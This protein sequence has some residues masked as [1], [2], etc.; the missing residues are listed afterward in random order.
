M[1]NII[2][3]VK[4]SNN[5]VILQWLAGIK[6]GT[7][8]R[9]KQ[10]KL[11]LEKDK[12]YYYKSNGP[13]KI[14]TI[15]VWNWTRQTNQTDGNIVFIQSQYTENVRP[16]EIIAIELQ[17]QSKSEVANYIRSN[18]I[19]AKENGLD[20]LICFPSSEKENLYDGVYCKNDEFE[21]I[22]SKLHL[23]D[24]IHK[25]PLF[26]I[27]SNEI[28]RTK[29]YDFYYRL[30]LGVANDFIE[31][32]E[33]KEILIDLLLEHSDW[34][35]MSAKGLSQKDYKI[36][37]KYL[38]DFLNKDF[39]EEFAERSGCTLT[40]AKAICRDFIKNSGTYLQEKSD[41][42]N[43]FIDDIFEHNRSLREKYEK[44]VDE[45]WN[46]KHASKI[47]AEQKEYDNLKQKIKNEQSGLQQLK[48]D[49]S[50][51]IK[52]L[53]QEKEKEA[54]ALEKW[55]EE[56]QQKKVNKEI[57]LNILKDQIDRKQKQIKELEQKV[58]KQ[59]EKAEKITNQADN[60]IVSQSK[61]INSI[62]SPQDVE[63]LFIEGKPLADNDIDECANWSDMCS[64]LKENFGIAGVDENENSILTGFVS[65]LYAAYLNEIPVLLA[66]PNAKNIAD[67]F[68]AAVYGKTADRFN[69]EGQYQITKLSNG[70]ESPFTVIDNVFHA[71]WLDHVDDI[72]S[73]FQYC[74][75][76][77]AFAE[78]LI[79][80]PR[81]LY[82][83]MIPV[84]TDL[85]VTVRPDTDPTYYGKQK[86]DFDIKGEDRK[87]RS[88]LKV[89]QG[90]GLGSL[91][92]RNIEMILKTLNGMPGYSDDWAYYFVL[93]P[94]AILTG[95]ER[96]LVETI[97]SSEKIS[98]DCRDIIMQYLGDNQ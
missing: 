26:Q 6:D 61:R 49:L 24:N 21:I 8:V 29:Q 38:N 41:G 94:Y 10:D 83:Y 44:R 46:E 13:E 20:V 57:E 86:Q 95:N 82:N 14:G 9:L 88:C 3:E 7:I 52:V 96:F 5:G 66:G 15:G 50:S 31:L 75:F 89:L 45:K 17:V 67:A 55:K 77:N 79:I 81:G 22:D 28:V 40:D 78:N 93:L 11:R 60:Q 18:A 54:H 25:F 85:F 74:W 16:I 30:E 68:S 32:K 39:Y 91:Y 63:K 4:P 59:R 36:V 70:N 92:R 43:Q 53:K 76:T 1:S 19:K 48:N 23:K 65:Y 64:I 35:S 72:T 87:I 27:D 69:C 90:F 51:E 42:E 2:C 73:E 34:A 62:E 80:E 98:N 71:N 37:N 47:Q 33:P 56:S 84:V 12:K 97:E 58:A